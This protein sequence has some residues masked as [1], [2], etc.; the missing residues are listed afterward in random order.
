VPDE[1]PSLLQ[2]SIRSRLILQK[3]DLYQFLRFCTRSAM[4]RSGVGA[5][6]LYIVARCLHGE[7]WRG[8]VLDKRSDRSEM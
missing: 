3:A 6:R 2:S 7:Q 1:D 8:F 5:F 4:V